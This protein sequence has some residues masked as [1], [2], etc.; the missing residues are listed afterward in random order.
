[1]AVFIPFSYKPYFREAH[2]RWWRTPEIVGTKAAGSAFSIFAGDGGGRFWFDPEMKKLTER[3][4]R[5]GTKLSSDLVTDET[6]K[7][8][9]MP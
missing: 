8:K 2:W 4:M 6:Y 7:P 5:D 3:A 9:G 1:M